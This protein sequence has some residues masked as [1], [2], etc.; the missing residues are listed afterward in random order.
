MA[1]QVTFRSALI[2]RTAGKKVFGMPDPVD[3]MPLPGHPRPPAVDP[4]Q[5]AELRSLS[6]AGDAWLVR[7]LI[8]PFL[9][10]SEQGL[11]EMRAGCM[12]ADAPQVERLA[13]NL[14]GSCGTVGVRILAE[15]ARQLMESAHAG[16]LQGVPALLDQYAAEHARVAAALRRE[17]PGL[18]A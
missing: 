7:E 14:K 6:P 15:I 16:E 1:R 13:H 10:G 11:R 9:Q 8:L 5:L 2:A 18:P 17:F 3:P 12:K 4:V